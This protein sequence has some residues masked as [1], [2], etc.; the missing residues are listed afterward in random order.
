MRWRLALTVLAGVAVLGGASFAQIGYVNQGGPD[1]D[2]EDIIV[3]IYE[4]TYLSASACAQLLGGSVLRLNDDLYGGGMGGYGRGRGSNGG[5][6]G[7]GRGGNGVGRGGYGGYGGYGGRGGNYGGGFEDGY[8]GY[9]YGGRNGG[10]GGS[11]GYGGY[12]G[13]YGW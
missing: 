13:G 1:D 4:P 10:R 8:G 11:G 7:Y 6:G 3:V 9:G 12:G 5:Y 2:P